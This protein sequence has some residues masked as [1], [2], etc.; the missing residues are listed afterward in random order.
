MI[1]IYAVKHYQFLSFA[2][3]GIASV[4]TIGNG[5][6]ELHDKNLY[7]LDYGPRNKTMS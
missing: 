6:S 7:L 4:V 1:N 5:L 3:L 2:Y